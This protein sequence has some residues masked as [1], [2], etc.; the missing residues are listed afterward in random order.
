MTP[1]FRRIR[2]KLANENKFLKYSRYAIGEIVLVVIGIL[3][4]LQ[5]NNWNEEN[6]EKIV[7]KNQLNE[8]SDSFSED[9]EILMKIKD[10]EMFRY[11]SMTYLLRIAGENPQLSNA[12]EV[13]ESIPYSQCWIWNKPIPLT[14]DKEFTTISFSWT[15]RY[16]PVITNLKAYDEIESTGMYSKLENKTL[17]KAVRKYYYNL[18]WQIKPFLMK[19]DPEVL[20][21]NESLV[22][23]GVDYINVSQLDDPINL[24]RGQ[25]ERI[26]MI[27]QLSRIANWKA[28]CAN[29]LIK[30]LD[31]I[32]E[33]IDREIE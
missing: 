15:A 10:I 4:A 20:R 28:I 26:T 30:E 18:E 21:W 33:I 8:L 13:I 24:I 27:R 16:N 3:I 25:P 11:H 17:K 9:R 22:R 2:L 19:S 14:E 12:K 7:I 23:Q 29:G 31:D 5:I 6:Q 32:I 1:F